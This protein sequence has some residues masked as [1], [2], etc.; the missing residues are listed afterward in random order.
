MEENKKSE[1][2]FKKPWMQSVLAIIVIFS[3]LFAFIYFESSKNKVF[4]E[5]AALTAPVVNLAPALPG[6]LNALYVK[7]GDKIAPNTQVAL[8]G[9]QIITSIEGGVVVSAPEVLGAYFNPGQTVVSVVKNEDM[10]AV[11]SVDETKGLKEIL[12]GQRATFT[13]DA[14]GGKTYE[15]IV[16]EVSP[17]SNDTGVSFSISDK[18]PVKKFDI[19]VRFNSAQYPELKSGMSAKITVFTK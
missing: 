14:Y 5:N 2:L 4:I 8:V 3:S 16:D 18:R 13:V 10:K 12:P 9:S 6:T 1:S 17:I 11:G 19:K 7:E 15:G